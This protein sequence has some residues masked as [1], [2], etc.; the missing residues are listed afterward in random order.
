MVYNNILIMNI[1]NILVDSKGHLI[2]IDFG[3][4]LSVSPGGI[5]FENVPFKL[6]KV[7][8]LLS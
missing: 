3:F 5:N 7:L 1:G 2:H 6:T 4:I 8:H